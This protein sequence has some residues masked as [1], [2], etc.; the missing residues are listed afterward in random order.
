M[1]WLWEKKKRTL[2]DDKVQPDRLL[3]NGQLQAQKK[4]KADA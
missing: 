2:I 3:G 1:G 4:G